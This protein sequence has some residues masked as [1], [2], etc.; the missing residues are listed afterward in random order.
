MPT[1]PIGVLLMS[2]GAAATPQDVPAYLA[3]VRR[4]K[5]TPDLVAEFQRR[6]RLAGGSPLLR[7]TWA[8]AMALESLLESDPPTPSSFDRSLESSSTPPFSSFP[9][10]PESSSAP[11]PPSFR[12]KPE[13]SDAPQDKRFMVS[14]GMRHAPPFMDEALSHLAAKGVSQVIGLIMSPQYSPYIMGGYHRALEEWQQG[15]EAYE[16][17]APRLTLRV[18]GAWHTLPTFIDALARRVRDALE[19]FPPSERDEVAVLMTAHSLPKVVADQEPGYL[20]QLRQT[21]EAVAQRVGLAPDCWQFAY[22]SAGHTPQEW[23]RPDIRELFP[24]LRQAGHRRALVVPIQFLSD[25]LEVLYDLDVA[26]T[27]QATESGIQ[28]TR[29]QTPGVMPELIQ[30][31]AEVVHREL[32]QMSSD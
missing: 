20:Q 5:P 21:A 10:S 29:I 6:Y 24:S 7:S 32:A 2:F 8:Q 9:Q 11:P 18:A 12:R 3:S 19:D 23:L 15:Y 17:V 22:Q 27:Q 28:M 13:S 26:A 16:M 4:A 14:V 31:L 1:S 25:H 30:T